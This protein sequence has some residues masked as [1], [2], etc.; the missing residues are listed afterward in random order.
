MTAALVLASFWAKS[1]HKMNRE[2]LL[3]DP[4]PDNKLML[5]M[6]MFVVC[7]SKTINEFAVMV[8]R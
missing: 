6:K 8:H 5:L 3:P 2:I 4:V 7:V 1:V